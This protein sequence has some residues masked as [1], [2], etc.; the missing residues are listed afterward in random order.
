MWLFLLF[1]ADLKLRSEPDEFEEV[2][3]AWALLDDIPQ[4]NPEDDDWKAIYKAYTEAKLE[5]LRL[6]K[7]QDLEAAQS[8]KKD[9][10]QKVST[11]QMKMDQ[12]W[13]AQQMEVDDHTGKFLVAMEKKKIKAQ[14]V[15]WT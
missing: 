5:E 1:T 14:R 9:F 6:E 8:S 10:G 11:F 2:G 13:E 12:K 4:F 7:A 15:G 3:S